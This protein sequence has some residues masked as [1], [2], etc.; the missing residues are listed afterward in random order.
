MTESHKFDLPFVQENLVTKQDFAKFTLHN[1]AF[2]ENRFEK[3]PTGNSLNY[4]GVVLG[5]KRYMKRYKKMEQQGDVLNSTVEAFIFTYLEL[6]VS[7]DIDNVSAP[8][9][10]LTIK[11]LN[12]P[13]LASNLIHSNYSILPDCY[14]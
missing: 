5:L 7:P 13:E 9:R 6:Y 8:L 1:F 10:E 2:Q 4:I 3:L 12:N 14:K 11:I